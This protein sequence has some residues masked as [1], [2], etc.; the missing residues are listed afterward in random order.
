MKK[1]KFFSLGISFYWLVNNFFINNVYAT[2]GMSGGG[3]GGSTGGG[4]SGLTGS[5]LSNPATDKMLQNVIAYVV[6]ILVFLLFV[7]LY[8]KNKDKQNATTSP[9]PPPPPPPPAKP[10]TYQPIAGTWSNVNGKDWGYPENTVTEI[11][12]TTGTIY[13]SKVPGGSYVIVGNTPTYINGKLYKEGDK[14]PLNKNDL[15]QSGG[16]TI[17]M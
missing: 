15:I 17:T 1:N 12:G 6:M 4:A 2:G 13:S 10:V 14:V 9:P 7:L 8:I 11:T 16:N 3:G 5:V